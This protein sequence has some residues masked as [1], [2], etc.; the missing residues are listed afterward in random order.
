MGFHSRLHVGPLR[1]A[2]QALP[3]WSVPPGRPLFTHPVA[4]CGSKR[5]SM[6]PSAW[7]GRVPS[8]LKLG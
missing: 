7:K 8:V 4:L 6:Q 2:L 3:T 1:L 5:S